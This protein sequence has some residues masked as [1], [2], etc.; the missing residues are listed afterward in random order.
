MMYAPAI[1]SDRKRT[2]ASLYRSWPDLGEG[3]TNRPRSWPIVQ[4]VWPAG[5]I[6]RTTTQVKKRQ[7][8]MAVG[9][10]LQLKCAERSGRT[11]E[12]PVETVEIQE[13]YTK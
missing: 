1:G 7:R 5:L 4:G 2:P 13:R 6:T 3:R 9:E 10:D 8:Y 12:M 11:L